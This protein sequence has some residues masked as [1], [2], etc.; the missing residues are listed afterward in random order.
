MVNVRSLGAADVKV[1]DR[2]AFNPENTVIHQ[3]VA[4]RHPGVEFDDH[5]ASGGNQSRLD[6]LLR[7]VE[8]ALTVDAFENPSDDMEGRNLVRADVAKIDAH[9]LS[10]IRLQRILAREGANMPVEHHVFGCFG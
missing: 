6:A 1:A 7:R 4:S 2:S 8:T 5:C 9:P 3:R 10:N